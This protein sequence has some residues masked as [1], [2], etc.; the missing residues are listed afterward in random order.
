M[1]GQAIINC[2]QEIYNHEIRASAPSP[3]LVGTGK[4]H[5]KLQPQEPADTPY[6]FTSEL[7][8]IEISMI[9]LIARHLRHYLSR[10]RG[11]RWTNR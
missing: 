5:N 10:V 7:V 3:E 11:K 2:K 4:V 1:K 9:S 6:Q 8:G